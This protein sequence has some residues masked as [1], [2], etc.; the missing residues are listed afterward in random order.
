MPRARHRI[1]RGKVGGT[2]LRRLVAG[3][4]ASAD[5]TAREEAEARRFLAE[6]EAYYSDLRANDPAEWAEVQRER[7][8]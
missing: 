1:E 5:A 4:Q 3:L 6:Y 2:A 8:I 7:A